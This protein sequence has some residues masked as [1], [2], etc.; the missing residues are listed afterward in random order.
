MPSAAA[1]RRASL[2]RRLIKATQTPAIG[3]NSGPTTMDPT[4]RTGLSVMIPTD[5]STI[6]MVTKARNLT[7]SSA[8]SEVRFS[9]SSQT[10]ASDGCP[11]AACS[12]SSKASATAVSMSCS[13]IEPS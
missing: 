7:E 5:A 3:P 13:A 1:D 11:G 8:L 9:T 4:T 2:P 6:A 12:A 10:T